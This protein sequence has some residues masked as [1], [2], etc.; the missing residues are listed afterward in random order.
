MAYIVENEV[1]VGALTAQL[2][3]LAGGYPDL[4]P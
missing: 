4:A 2:E 1:V 3:S